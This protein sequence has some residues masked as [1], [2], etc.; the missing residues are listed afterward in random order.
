MV[1]A[2]TKNITKQNGYMY[3]HVHVSLFQVKK[4]ELVSQAEEEKTKIEQWHEVCNNS[5]QCVYN[6]IFWAEITVI[7]TKEE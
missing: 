5:L 7:V 1:T 4:S 3:C 2:P 6:N